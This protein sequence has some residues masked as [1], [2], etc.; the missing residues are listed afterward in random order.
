MA[1]DEGVCDGDTLRVGVGVGVPVREAETEA[2]SVGAAVRDAVAVTVAERVKDPDLLDVGEIAEE[3]KEQRKS[4][5][6]AARSS[7]RRVAMAPAY[8][9]GAP[10]QVCVGGASIAPSTR[11]LRA[12]PLRR[13]ARR[14]RGPHSKHALIRAPACSC[15]PIAG[16]RN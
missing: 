8:A 5:S 3:V 1:V 14:C 13:R 7:V 2:V 12:R 4:R 15:I 10:R 6:K 11:F 9:G 16:R